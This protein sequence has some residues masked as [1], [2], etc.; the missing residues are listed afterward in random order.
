MRGG[1]VGQD[2]GHDPSA[3]QLGQHLGDVPHQ[4]HGER[5]PASSRILHESERFVEIVRDPIAVPGLHST[6]DARLVHIHA[7]ERRTVHRR[8]EWLGSSHSAEPAGH[9]EATFESSAEVLSRALGKGLI[10]PLQNPL[11]PDVDPRSC[12]HLAVHRETKRVEAAELVPRRPARDQMRVRDQHPRS[13]LVSPE[14]TH[15]LPALHEERF[16]VLETAERADDPFVAGPVAGRLPAPAVH[17]QV[18]RP[19]GDGRIEVVHQHPERRLLMP[20]LTGDGGP[21]GG[22]DRG[23]GGG[24]SHGLVADG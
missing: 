5:L 21:G 3:D 9:D 17:D 15:G 24:C 16:V 11:G 12:R 7:E 18:L 4:S 20:A 23:V 10:G 13:F 6:D 1:L 22:G 2:V 19:L 8:R 14:H